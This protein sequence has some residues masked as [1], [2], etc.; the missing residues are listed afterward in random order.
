MDDVATLSL[1][2]VSIFAGVLLG[3]LYSYLHSLNEKISEIK[4]D[5]AEI[6]GLIQNSRRR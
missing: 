2:I 4:T 3:N 6:K 1:A 5:L